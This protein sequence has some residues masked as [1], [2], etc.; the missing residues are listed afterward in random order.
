MGKCNLHT[1]AAPVL[2]MKLF[3]APFLLLP[4]YALPALAQRPGGGMPAGSR[5]MSANGSV[6]GKIVN[7]KTGKPVD[8][9][10]VLLLA[11]RGEN[12]STGGTLVGNALTEGNGEFMLD[13]LPAGKP[14]QLVLNAIG[15]QSQKFSVTLGG[16]NIHKDMGNIKVV[17]NDETQLAEVE[18]VSQTPQFELRGEKKVFN[19][20]QNLSAQG[21]MVT[22][23]LRNVPG[24]QVDA[25]G[26]VTIRNSGPQVFVDGRQTTL[27][28]DQ[29]PADAVEN[30][31]IINNPSAKFDAAGG[32]G[33]IL[34]VVL[35]KN[36]K[37]GYNG[38]V[39]AGIDSRGGGNLDGDINIR[40]G[41]FNF[42]IGANGRKIA[43]RTTTLT[44]R[45]DLLSTPS[46]LTGQDGIWKM[47]GYR[48]F[49]RLGVDYFM[50]N[51]T[52][53]SLAANLSKGQFDQNENIDI[54]GRS[55]TSNG[56]RAPQYALRTNDG[57]RIYNNQGV[58]LGGKHL[59]PQA[60]RELTVDMNYNQYA[61]D[62]DNIFQTD[63]FTS[64]SHETLTQSVRQ[65]TR[66]TGSS[67]YSVL[68]AD[69]VQ[70]IN[71][72]DKLELGVKG[73]F[74]N[75]DNENNN[76]VYNTVKGDFD[77]PL[78]NPFALYKSNDRVLAAYASYSGNLSEKFG[79][80]LGLRGESS[81]YEGELTRSGQ[82][83][84]NSFPVSFFPSAFVSQQLS[85]TDQ[86]QFS[87]RRGI[88][89]PGFWQLY[90]FADYTDPLNIR[91]GNANLKPAFTNSLELTYLKTGKGGNYASGSAYYRRAEGVITAYQSLTTNPF[92][93]S[94]AVISTYANLGT[95][96]QYG[97][98][99]TAQY[100]PKKWWTIVANLNGYNAAIVSDS[101][102]TNRN[103]Y[104]SAF[105]KLNNTFKL[106]KSLTLQFL[107]GY[108]SRTSILPDGS[109]GGHWGGGG[110]S[111]TAQGYIGSNWFL[112]ASVR[113]GWGKNDVLS[114][115]LSVNDVF[116]TQRTIQHTEN[117]YFIQDYNR[118]SNPYTVRLNLAWRFG[119]RDVDLF[120]RKTKGADGGGG[121]EF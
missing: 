29:I 21:G 67:S 88:D 41:K 100:L 19:V 96:S 89:R 6:Y 26:N 53:I 25:D 107:A 52:S 38:N 80:Q 61:S 28:L 32:G 31:E 110:S 73:V 95:T 98:E 97:V 42:S 14:L 45:E 27:S 74:R 118:L 86:L 117:A 8:G 121:G 82:Q 106:Q 44:E 35:K 102:L 11:P 104:L 75:N 57:R 120:R 54:L 72:T 33:G 78:P 85:K 103:N 47:D 56:G 16:G 66:G 36:R 94:D 30:I 65:R 46:F 64:A 2:T 1:S 105:A 15:Y 112:D 18:I 79:Y 93:N 40:S 71:K 13:G 58:S 24:V 101:A 114:A 116:G 55:V 77:A 92:T 83:F 49:G 10:S 22:D 60:G 43:R 9:A 23:V 59:F 99:L 63:T 62:N 76:Y 111:S 81:A 39:R 17:P 70:P 37:Q 48:G 68:Q 109:G 12:D 50:T 7:S 51:R 113:K 84:S 20:D 4:F 5:A 115:T 34:N 87:Y 91:Q 3:Y 108:Q 69:Y 90:P 119:E